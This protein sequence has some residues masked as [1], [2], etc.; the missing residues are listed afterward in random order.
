[1]AE[2]QMMDEQVRWDH[3]MQ[4][5]TNAAPAAGRMAKKRQHD[6]LQMVKQ[7]RHET[8][9]D[10]DGRVVGALRPCVVVNFNP[11]AL[12]VEGQI[13]CKV[14]APGT[15]QH[16]QIKLKW[17]GRQVQGH[18][19]LIAS[20]MVDFP[21]PD[22][23]PVYYSRVTGHETDSQSGSDQPVHAPKCFP[24]HAIGCEI[25]A[26]Y[27]DPSTKLMGGI[28]L[29]DQD[30]QALSSARLEEHGGRI[31]VPERIRI[32]DSDTF[33]YS[34]RETTLEEEL[35]RVLGTQRD[36]CDVILQQA[37]SFFTS[38]DDTQ[39]KMVTDTHRDWD[40]YAVK[41]AWKPG[42]SEFTTAKM[43]VTDKILDLRT[44]A[45]CGTQQPNPDVHFCKQCNAPYD[46]FAAYMK[47]LHVPQQYLELLPDEQLDIVLKRRDKI[48]KRFAP[49]AE[50]PAHSEPAK[51]AK[52]ADAEK[53]A[54]TEN[55]ADLGPGRMTK[56]SGTEKAAADGKKPEEKGK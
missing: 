6:I 29:V 36:Y 18:Y 19:M 48:Q 53:P 41:M 33:S 31:W 56:P 47:G 13:S 26:M 25:V 54:E 8:R 21:K 51:P 45:Y 10:R 14:P 16:H 15:T 43:V 35:D 12:V 24:P 30:Q 17:R 52:A 39:K 23:Q 4:S 1:M 50:K 22:F 34:L 38:G 27:N 7:M 49:K 37:H 40:R 20:P 11:L 2:V 28:L 3:G 9:R 5:A 42:L 32:D 44:C 55:P 46:A